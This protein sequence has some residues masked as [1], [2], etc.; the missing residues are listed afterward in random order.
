MNFENNWK[1]KQSIST[2]DSDTKIFPT[3]IKDRTFQALQSGY[4]I[5]SLVDSIPMNKLKANGFY[6]RKLDMLELRSIICLV[7]LLGGLKKNL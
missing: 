3:S 7:F 5:T 6:V 1:W 2:T 4:W